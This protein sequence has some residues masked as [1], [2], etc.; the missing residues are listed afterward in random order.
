MLTLAIGRSGQTSGRAASRAAGLAG[1]AALLGA[2]GAE[3]PF[4][5]LG[6][7]FVGREDEAG[8][9]VNA[10]SSAGAS[11]LFT[12]EWSVCSRTMAALACLIA[13]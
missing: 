3:C 11:N 6:I 13:Y 5:M 10:A 1:R 4:G 9:G 12:V 7:A 8:P 2:C